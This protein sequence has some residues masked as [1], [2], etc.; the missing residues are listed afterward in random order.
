M[1]NNPYRALI[2]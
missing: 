1:D 2:H